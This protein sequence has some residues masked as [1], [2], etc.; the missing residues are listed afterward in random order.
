MTVSLFYFRAYFF[1]F[2]SH[3]VAEYFDVFILCRIVTFDVYAVQIRLLA[4]LVTYWLVCIGE[5]MVPESSLQDQEG[6]EGP[7]SRRASQIL[8]RDLGDEGP[9]SRSTS[10]ILLGDHATR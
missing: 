3:T 7:E 1:F 8:L 10:S 4:Y 2:V 5:D 6:A 9:E